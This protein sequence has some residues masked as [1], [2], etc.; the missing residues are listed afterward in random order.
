MNDLWLGLCLSTAIADWV[1]VAKGETRL[2]R[3]AK[4][5]TLLFLLLWFLSRTPLHGGSLFFALGLFF[6]LLGDLALLFEG[7]FLPGLFAFLLAHLAYIFSINTPLAEV[8][9]L[10]SV[11]IAIVLA[12]S[13][14]RL[15]RRIAQGALERQSANLVVPIYVY[16]LTLTLM[17]LSALMTLFRP[18]W[19]ARASLSL[20][21]G[22]LFFY[23][24]DLILAWNRFVR[25]L[26][27]GRLWN[28]ILYHLGQV[29]LTIGA[30]LHWGGAG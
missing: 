29:L 5:L 24:S 16:G 28:M 23:V 12:L 6:S 17:I 14:A 30:F 15:L 27:N 13:A 3:I 19:S 21:F 2:E 9:P 7:W 1:A 4:P 8:S 10:W 18:D 25:P 22:A 26:R 20:S 11:P